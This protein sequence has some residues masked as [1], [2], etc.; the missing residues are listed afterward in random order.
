MPPGTLNMLVL[1][2][3][4]I[5]LRSYS[6]IVVWPIIPAPKNPKHEDTKF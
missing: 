6:D 1:L 4:F 2:G 5:Y 3:P